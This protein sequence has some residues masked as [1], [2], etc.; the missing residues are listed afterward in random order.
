MICCDVFASHY[1]STIGSQGNLSPSPRINQVGLKNSLMIVKFW[2]SVCSFSLS[3]N[4]AQ[5]RQQE[6]DPSDIGQSVENI[7]FLDQSEGRITFRDQSGK[8][9]QLFS[10]QSKAIFLLVFLRLV[11]KEFFKDLRIRCPVRPAVLSSNR[12]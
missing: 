9:S 3:S 1:W 5:N 4:C 10:D 11:P 12:L 8:G 2:M 7:P 6:P